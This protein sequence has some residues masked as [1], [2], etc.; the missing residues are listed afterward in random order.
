MIKTKWCYIVF[1]MESISYEQFILRNAG[2]V[3]EKLQS[4]IRKTRLLI[5]GCGVGSFIAEAALRI[6][7]E[8]LTLVDGDKIEAHNLNRQDFETNDIG[9]QKV[10]ALA[11]RLSAIYPAA[12]IQTHNDWVTPENALNFVR[13]ADFIFDMIDF[14]SLEGI[15]AL[16][17]A[18]RQLKKPIISAF[19]VGW[20]AG[21][22]Y[23]PPGGV[24]FRQLFGLPAE[25]SV[26]DVSYVKQFAIVIKKLREKLNP[27]V[28][29]V[30]SKALTVME[31]DTPCPAPHVS[32]GT[33]AVSSLVITMLVRLLNDEAV[34]AAPRMI[35][36]DLSNECVKK[37]IELT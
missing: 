8:Q 25:G 34:T 24:T 14:L 20:G 16:H 11:R 18:C 9:H 2:Y 6:G 3:S 36:V 15:V 31:D 7:F 21:A 12:S 27:T 4:R 33:M 13:E 30:I 22:V 17:D 28:V 19:P 37:A 29:E 35:L 32:V 10:D 26:K 1:I 23:F 5:A